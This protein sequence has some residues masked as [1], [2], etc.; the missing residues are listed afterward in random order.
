MDTSVIQKQL[1]FSG[2]KENG[3]L[4]VPGMQLS[5]P[6]TVLYGTKPGPSVLITAGIHSTEYV[7]I[8]AL[9]ELSQEMTAESLCG[10][11]VL[12]PL[13]NRSGFENRTA[14]MVYEDNRNLNRLF[15]GYWDGSASDRLAAAVYT[16][17]IRHADFYIDLHCG[18]CWE[19]LVP[20][21]YYVGG[22]EV[23]RNSREM[24]LCTNV[25]YVVRSECRTGG[26]YNVASVHKLP[27][28]L[29]ERGNQ[30]CWSE[31]EVN[32]DKKDIINILRYIR[33][34]DE[35]P[36]RYRPEYE[37]TRVCYINAPKAGCW[38][39]V[40]KV[41]ESVRKNELIGEIKGYQGELKAAVFADSA[42]II[43]YQTTALNVV[44]NGSVAAYGVTECI[45]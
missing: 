34:Q 12:V 24:A 5:I 27:S 13:V 43:L 37:F 31:E 33:M 41:G 9:I 26:A 2:R 16:A 20:Y 19:E 8:Q 22:T 30:G 17:F 7:G 29:L 28:I 25:P 45:L 21:V 6:Y 4:P 3:M 35:E 36:V 11:L 14:G 32:A 39:P 44:E 15:P 23:E 38:Y 1:L 42:G 10:N 18:D 40:K